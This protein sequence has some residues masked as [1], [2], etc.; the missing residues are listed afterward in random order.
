MTELIY[1]KMLEAQRL[2][3]KGGIEKKDRNKFQNFNYRSVDSTIAAASAV[4][5]TVGIFC[6]PDS[7]QVEWITKEGKDKSGNPRMDYTLRASFT[8]TF[9]A[10]DGSFV[11]AAAIPVANTAQDDS[12]LLGQ[13]L[14]Y[15]YKEVLFKTFSIPVEGVEDVDSLDSERNQP[16]TKPK[17]TITPPGPPLSQNVAV[18]ERKALHTK[19]MAGLKANTEALM[20]KP[21]L[22]P[23][24]MELLEEIEG[25]QPLPVSPTTRGLVRED[26][27]PAVSLPCDDDDYE[28][29]F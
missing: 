8:F 2:F 29:P 16:P 25:M 5:S 20:Q 27:T 10:E 9:Y 19:A 17:G 22:S 11:K 23:H 4:F 6:V 1:A 24:Y 18:E 14:S 26:S 28:L 3:G 21:E 13:C 12:K 15:A 7:P